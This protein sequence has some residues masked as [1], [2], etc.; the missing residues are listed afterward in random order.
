MGACFENPSSTDFFFK[1]I[2]AKLK[3]ASFEYKPKYF[4]QLPSP[5]ANPTKQAAVA[6]LV[7][8]ILAAKAAEARSL[9]RDLAGSGVAVARSL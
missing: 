7:T 2:G 1:F 9:R 4:T 3:D 8:I 6:S 5:T